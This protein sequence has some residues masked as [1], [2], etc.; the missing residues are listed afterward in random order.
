MKKKILLDTIDRKLLQCCVF[1][2]VKWQKV[3]DFFFRS[4]FESQD[5]DLANVIMLQNSKFYS[6]AC[7]R[8]YNEEYSCN[9]IQSSHFNRSFF[10]IIIQ[11]RRDSLN[12]L[13]ALSRA[14]NHKEIYI[15]K[16]YIS[17]LLEWC[18]T[19][20]PLTVARNDIV[21]ASVPEEI[22]G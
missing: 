16:N 8:G 5:I 18:W 15:F 12:S 1:Y 2:R 4:S 7:K 3:L 22:D 10:R 14:T 20:L 9:Y 21:I 19:Q 11:R 6:I 17:R 13:V